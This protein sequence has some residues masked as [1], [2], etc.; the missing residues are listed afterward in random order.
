M[1]DED[2]LDRDQDGYHHH[3]GPESLMQFQHLTGDPEL[4][5][6]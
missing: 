3:A 4:L 1:R 2:R 6:R 5:L